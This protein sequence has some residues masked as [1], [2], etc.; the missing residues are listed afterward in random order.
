M[1]QKIVAVI[2]K[3]KSFTAPIKWNELEISIACNGD[4]T[5]KLDEDTGFKETVDEKYHWEFPNNV[6]Y[7]HFDSIHQA[8]ELGWKL[9]APPVKIPDFMFSGPDEYEWWLI[10]D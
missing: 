8:I 7:R 3:Y 1:A 9:L 2:T 5:S 10:R 6:P 4:R